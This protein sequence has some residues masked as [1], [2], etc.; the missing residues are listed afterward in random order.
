MPVGDGTD[1]VAQRSAPALTAAGWAVGATCTAAILGTPYL[2]FGYHSPELHLVLDSVD[3]CIAMLLAYLLAGRLRRTQRL[4]DLLLVVGLVL[5]ALVGLG[6]ALVVHRFAEPTRQTFGVW[7]PVSV[8]TAASLL[9]A[10]AAVVPERT[11]TRRQIGRGA[12]A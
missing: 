12:R 6:V 1:R 8:R 10:V 11:L 2:R 9:I 5:L 7:L 4:Q 3:A